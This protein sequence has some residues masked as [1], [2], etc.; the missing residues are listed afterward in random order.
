M[1]P[2]TNHAEATVLY[3]ES[4]TRKNAPILDGRDC[5][6]LRDWLIKSA[7]FCDIAVMDY[8]I[9]P[10]R[11]LC[12]VQ[13]PQ[14]RHVTRDELLER[15]LSIY[16]PAA[17]QRRIAEIDYYTA[18]GQR[19][20]AAEARERITRRMY[21]ESGLMKLTKKSFTH[22]FNARHHRQG[23]IWSPG[24]FRRILADRE[25]IDTMKQY[26]YY[27]PV[28]AGVAKSPLKHPYCSAAN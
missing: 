17:A 1:T 4:R 26:I 24:F 12:I 14:R 11:M 22:R 13:I 16:S 28:E 27:A 15:M 6:I 23:S 5:E 7:A 9:L 3:C 8:C 19:E 18:M 2:Q 20:T 25:A 10:N 21:S